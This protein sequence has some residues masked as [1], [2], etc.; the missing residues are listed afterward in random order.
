MWWTRRRVLIAG[1]ASAAAVATVVILAVV[2]VPQHFS[3]H[4]AAIYDLQ[5]CSG[6]ETTI[7]TS[8]TFHWSAP[9]PIYFFVV[10][11]SASQVAYEGNGTDGSGSLVSVGGAYEFGASCPEGTCVPADVSGSLTGPLLNL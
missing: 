3:T 5:P 4:G 1:V 8:V 2:P 9:S 10:S 6:I 11:C 7:G